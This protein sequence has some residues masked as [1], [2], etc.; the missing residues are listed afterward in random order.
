MLFLIFLKPFLFSDTGSVGA[1][2]RHRTQSLSVVASYLFLSATIFSNPPI[3]FGSIA[4]LFE[5]NSGL[6]TYR[7]ND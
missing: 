7:S 3:R 5:I 2:A 4:I 6:R 1:V